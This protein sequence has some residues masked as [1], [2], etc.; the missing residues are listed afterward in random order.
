MENIAPALLDWF[1]TNRRIL[2]FR[3]D[4]TPYHVWLSE[5]MLQQTRVSAA[6]PYYERFLAALPDIPALAACEEEKLHKLWEGLGYYS[7]VRNLQKAAR[8][9][10]E[11]YGGQL[12]ADYDALRALPGI[13]D[14]TAGAIASISF[15][16]AVPAVDGNVLRVMARLRED[17]EDILKQSVKNR[18]EA[19]LTEIMPAE[20]PGAFNQAMMDLGAMVCLPNGAPKCEVCPLFDQCLA[21]QHQTWTEYPFKKSAKPRRIEDRTVLLFLD[22]VHTAVRKRP[23]KGLLAGLYEFPNF[24]GVLSEQEA[25]EEAE[26]FG[27]TPLHI[28][29]LPPYKHI[30]SHIEWHIT[31]YAIKIAGNDVEQEGEEKAGL[32]FAD[33]KTAAERYAIPS[34]FAEYA[35]YTDLERA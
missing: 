3:E 4:P 23:K 30:F 21:G 24:D 28:Q 29:A 15:G 11:Q 12:P 22:G 13:G 8:I 5:I 33:A 6:L 7:R 27:V 35:K 26:K 20:D 10:C 2:P 32:I 17:G 31:G 18:V 9:V 1:Y 25:L 19:E 16:L 34:A 14:Y